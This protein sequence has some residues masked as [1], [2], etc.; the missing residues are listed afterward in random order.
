MSENLKQLTENN[1]LLQGLLN[2]FRTDP[3]TDD[4]TLADVLSAVKALVDSRDSMQL[5]YER[6]KASGEELQ[7]RLGTTYNDL[8]K[9]SSDEV[10]LLKAQLAEMKSQFDAIVTELNVTNELVAPLNVLVT[11]S[12]NDLKRCVDREHQYLTLTAELSKK[13]SIPAQQQPQV[14]TPI[15]PISIPS[16]DQKGAEIT[17]LVTPTSNVEEEWKRPE[18]DFYDVT[19]AVNEEEGSPFNFADVREAVDEA[20][21]Q[22]PQKPAFDDIL[23]ASIVDLTARQ[24]LM[25]DSAQLYAYAKAKNITEATQ[26]SD[27]ETLRNEVWGHKQKAIIGDIFL[28]E[29]EIAQ[30][31]RDMLE[32]VVGDMYG[33][34]NGK[35]IESYTDDSLRKTATQLKKRVDAYRELERIN[36]SLLSKLHSG[37]NT[38]L[39]NYIRAAVPY[40]NLNG[41]DQEQDHHTLF[42][43]AVEVAAGLGLTSP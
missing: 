36:P 3:I 1:A 33:D 12:R 6:Q 40:F 14:T 24:L 11:K 15:S 8:Q 20:E 19:E 16:A 35:P 10:P 4:M 38:Q 32:S 25:M 26:F 29:E 34:Y 22:T 37:S 43:K 31:D 30:W 17:G 18:E 42:W 41:V 21:M 23:K 9:C 28:G 13:G 2:E 39:L 5:A 27:E 7:K